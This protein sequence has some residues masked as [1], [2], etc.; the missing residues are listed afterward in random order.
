MVLLSGDGIADG[1]AKER[2]NTGHRQKGDGNVSV[3]TVG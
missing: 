1:S 2:H 3:W